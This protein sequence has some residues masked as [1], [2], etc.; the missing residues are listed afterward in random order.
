MIYKDGVLLIPLSSIHS[1]LKA[2]GSCLSGVQPILLEERHP[3]SLHG[4]EF[5]H[6]PT[7]IGP[8]LLI[9]AL[10]L[11][12]GRGALPVAHTLEELEA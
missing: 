4:R 7:L 2:G 1:S 9:L 8:I 6:A 10:R 5:G 12:H 11:L 3:A